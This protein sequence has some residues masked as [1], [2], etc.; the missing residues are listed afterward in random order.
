VREKKLIGVNKL[1]ITEKILC[2]KAEVK[3]EKCFIIFTPL[4]E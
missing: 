3:K 1:I 2:P 4:A